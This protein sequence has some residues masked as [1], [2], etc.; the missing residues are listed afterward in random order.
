MPGVER[1]GDS[2]VTDEPLFIATRDT[3]PAFLQTVRDAQASLV[4]FRR[5]LQSSQAAEWY[6]CVKTRLTAG[7]E[8]AFV[9]LLVV[10]VMRSGFMASVF[11]IPPQFE[12]VRVGDEVRVSDDEVMDWMLNQNGVLHG[13]FS[14]RYQRSLLPPEKHAW[15]DRHIGVS[16]Y[17]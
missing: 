1:K 8:T 3:D 12:G 4:G 17:A 5:L 16:E 14:L 2:R 15:Y 9:W 6:P 7:S 13:G 11:E 10:R